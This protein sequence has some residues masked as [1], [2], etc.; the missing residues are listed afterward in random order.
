MKGMA[1]WFQTGPKN[2]A[3]HQAAL[4]NLRN[5]PMTRPTRLRSGSTNYLNGDIQHFTA[6]EVAKAR[7]VKD[8]HP[9]RRRF[10]LR[11][12]CLIKH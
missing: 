3:L 6:A 9:L 4:I 7:H 10:L 11:F 2:T 8:N 1:A 5:E 12:M